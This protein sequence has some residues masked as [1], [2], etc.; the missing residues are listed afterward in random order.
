MISRTTQMAVYL[1]DDEEIRKNIC[2][3]TIARIMR[4]HPDQDLYIDTFMGIYTDK[5]FRDLFGPSGCRYGLFYIPS[6]GCTSGFI[7]SSNPFED[8]VSHVKEHIEKHGTMSTICFRENYSF[9]PL[10]DTEIDTEAIFNTYPQ[11]SMFEIIK[12]NIY[13]RN[14]ERSGCGACSRNKTT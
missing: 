4:M 11:L 6:L 13:I 8:L 12:D 3:R 7:S 1:S 14:V 9:S 2:L 5:Y 10:I